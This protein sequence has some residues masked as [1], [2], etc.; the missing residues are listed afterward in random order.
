MQPK[1]YGQLTASEKLPMETQLERECASV[2]SFSSLTVVWQLASLF[3]VFNTLLRGCLSSGKH[4]DSVEM[5]YKTPL[6]SRQCALLGDSSGRET[7][8]KATPRIERTRWSSL[9]PRDRSPNELRGLRTGLGC[10]VWA[11][12]GGLQN[13]VA[14]VLRKSPDLLFVSFSAEWKGGD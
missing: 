6:A 7:A 11:G 8:E 4:Q 1:K 12:G 14:S 10:P 2:K 13:N 5:S 3:R 9:H